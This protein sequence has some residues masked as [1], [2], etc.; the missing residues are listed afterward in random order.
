M[1]KIS[2][3][4]TLK[5]V[6]ELYERK[7]VTYPRTDARVAPTAV[8]KEIS[9]NIGGRRIMSRWQHLRSDARQLVGRT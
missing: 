5:V 1:F 3:D 8:A 9:K 6:Q 7:L 2:P 4:R